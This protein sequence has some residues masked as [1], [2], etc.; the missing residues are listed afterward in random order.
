MMNLTK[1][2]LILKDI[3]FCAVCIE[4]KSMIILLLFQFVLLYH[5]IMDLTFIIIIIS[6]CNIFINFR[7]SMQRWQYLI[8]N[9]ILK[10]FFGQVRIK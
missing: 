8:H 4:N 1:L 3:C 7:P 10:S 6:M 5:N 2:I 9:C